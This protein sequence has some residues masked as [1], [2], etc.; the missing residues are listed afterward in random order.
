MEI[1]STGQGWPYTFWYGGHIGR[2]DIKGGGHIGR[3]HLGEGGHKG[4]WTRVHKVCDS[5]QD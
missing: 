3:E 5:R 2:G 4:G 1:H